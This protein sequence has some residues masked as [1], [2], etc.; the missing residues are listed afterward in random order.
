MS[1]R[2]SILHWQSTE[3]NRESSF[4]IGLN[5]GKKYLT[6]NFSLFKD[7]SY[8]KTSFMKGWRM[9]LGMYDYPKFSDNFSRKRKK[10]VFYCRGFDEQRKVT[11]NKLKKEFKGKLT[12]KDIE[13]IL[14]TFENK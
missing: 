6:N 10:D 7:G 8:K 9:G 2:Q 13:F 5:D 3:E 4:K 11:F 14:K 1:V 12:P